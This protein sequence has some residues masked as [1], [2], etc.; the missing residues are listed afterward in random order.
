V[1]RI[2][3]LSAAVGILTGVWT[4]V[5]G[6]FDGVRFN[7]PSVGCAGSTIPFAGTIVAA[8]SVLLIL[9]SVVCIVGPR[10]VFYGSAMISILLGS[11]VT[12]ESGAGDPTILWLTLGLAGATFVLSLLSARI[13]TAVSEQSHPM[14]LPVFG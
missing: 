3:T 6:F 7:C 2:G 11:L 4:L 1:V 13:K 12:L 10:S 14:N 5:A 8:L 9:V